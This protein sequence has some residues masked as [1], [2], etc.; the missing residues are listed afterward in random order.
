MDHEFWIERWKTQDI[1]FHQP[2]FEPA[3]DKYWSRLGLRPGARVFVP[4]CGK[5]LDMQW[6]A[7]HAH[8]VVG[9]ELS[10][11][12][13]DEFFAERGLVPDVRREAGRHDRPA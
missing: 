6:L 5:S 7:E 1:G 4:L 12:A 8:A 3:L 9:A 11:Q 13:V 10:E 2:Q